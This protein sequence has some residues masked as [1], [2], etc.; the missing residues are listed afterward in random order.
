MCLAIFKPQNKKVLKHEMENAFD[1]NDDGAGFAYP[2]NGKVEIQ[3]GY[4]KFEDFWKAIQPHMDKP[5]VIHF[6]WTTHGLTNKDNCHPFRVTDNLVM[7]HNGM[8]NGIDINDKDKSDTRTFVDD[9]VKP[10]NKGNPRFIYTEY[11]NRTLKACIGSSKLVFLNKKGE[12]VIVNE[13]AGHW[14]DGVWYSN[15]SYK[16][17]KVRYS[18]FSSPYYSA[19]HCYSGTYSSTKKSCA[20]PNEVVGKPKK[21]K[22]K[23]KARW[24][25]KSE[26][27]AIQE[28]LEHELNQNFST[29]DMEQDATLSQS[30]F[31]LRPNLD[32]IDD[33]SGSTYVPL[34]SEEY[35]L[36]NEEK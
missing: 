21:V 27:K 4:F 12:S 33:A 6:R 15:D 31:P 1:N 36:F 23:K 29:S 24:V 25:P 7:I 26:R 32:A 11:G 8:I 19:S 3:K 9:Y 34:I 35:N 22:G 13:S 2:H 10:I 17:I 16:T 5:M 30:D 28:E 18:N 20:K 14:Q